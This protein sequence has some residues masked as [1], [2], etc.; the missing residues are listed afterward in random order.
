MALSA[1]ISSISVFSNFNLHSSNFFLSSRVSDWISSIA[2]ATEV[3]FNPEELTDA[4][5]GSAFV[6]ASSSAWRGGGK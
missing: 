3:R 6:A 4:L 5:A 2:A 1:V